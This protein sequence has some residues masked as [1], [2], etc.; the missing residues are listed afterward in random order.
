MSS[1]KAGW[2]GDTPD[3][4]WRKDINRIIGASVR[5]CFS[6]RAK[7]IKGTTSSVNR[8]GVPVWRRTHTLAGSL[9]ASR[10]LVWPACLRNF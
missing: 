9:L 10:R 7:W 5:Y 8:E 3:N 2:L 4:T 6:V 1:E